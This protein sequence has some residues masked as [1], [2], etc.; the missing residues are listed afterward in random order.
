MI[1]SWYC[2]PPPIWS[3]LHHIGH[4]M[5][6]S[7]WGQVDTLQLEIDVKSNYVETK[8]SQSQNLPY[9]GITNIW[10]IA[11]CS[12][13]HTALHTSSTSRQHIDYKWN[14]YQGNMHNKSH[15]ALRH[16]L[17]DRGPSWICISI[18]ACLSSTRGM[19][20]SL[21]HQNEWCYILTT[22]DCTSLESSGFRWTCMTGLISCCVFV[23]PDLTWFACLC[24]VLSEHSHY[25]S[26]SK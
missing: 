19:V 18:L 5:F 7:I 26:C 14:S 17:Q 10:F 16:L 24:C 20:Q 12:T 4:K 8:E 9:F 3:C 21:L 13:T 6:H 11:Q 23:F 2:Y 1:D 25:T 22:G 15:K